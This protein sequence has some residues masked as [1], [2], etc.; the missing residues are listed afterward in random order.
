[1]DLWK[2]IDKEDAV[3]I[4]KNQGEK[5]SSGILKSEYFGGV[6]RG[7][8][9]ATTTFIVALSPGQSD[10]I[11]FRPWSPIDTGNHLDIAEVEK[12]SKS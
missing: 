5:I 8:S 2:I 10:I 6:G 9:Y 11:N 1:L 7:D 4:I 12:N 3:L